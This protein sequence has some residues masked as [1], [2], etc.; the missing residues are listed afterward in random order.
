MSFVRNVGTDRE[1]VLS[2]E[3][4]GFMTR[5]GWVGACRPRSYV[6]EAPLAA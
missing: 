6:G 3:R 4:V 2:Y 1:N 5:S